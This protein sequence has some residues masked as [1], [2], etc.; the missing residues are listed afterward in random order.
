MET[1]LSTKRVVLPGLITVTAL[2]SEGHRAVLDA[3]VVAVISHP[4]GDPVQ[5]YL[6][7]EGTGPDQFA[8]DGLY[9]G[10][11]T[12]FTMSGRYNVKVIA[13]ALP[14]YNMDMTAVNNGSVR[15]E[16]LMKRREA[17]AQYP[18][19]HM[20]DSEFET[21]NPEHEDP[22]SVSD[23]MRVKSAG[24][25]DVDMATM[26]NATDMFPPSRIMDLKGYR[27]VKKSE[28]IITL[29]WT[30]PGDDMET[31]T[32]KRERVRVNLEDASLI[33]RY[34]LNVVYDD[35]E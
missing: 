6:R 3:T 20:D 24:M 23:F 10:T 34:A 26:S 17:V 11:F 7:D 25:F 35:L 30:A 27:K 22:L 1:F 14:R 19:R 9:T 8:G 5:M 15:M 29:N 2:L 16:K 31:G 13:T 32:G 33:Q 18:P 4:N 12:E 28:V 21:V